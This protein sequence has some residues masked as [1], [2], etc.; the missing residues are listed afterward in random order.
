MVIL[1][2]LNKPLSELL[3][4]YIDGRSCRAATRPGLARTRC[5]PG[6]S[7]PGPLTAF[8]EETISLRAFTPPLGGH[9]R[10]RIKTVPALHTNP[11][12]EVRLSHPPYVPIG[13]KELVNL[14]HVAV[15]IKLVILEQ[16]V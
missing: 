3:E 1:P 11:P 13:R 7:V 6:T 14:H 10:T 12:Y 15:E 9:T 8:S 4:L 2:T 16:G 5:R